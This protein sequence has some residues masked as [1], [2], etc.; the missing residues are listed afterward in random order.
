VLGKENL[1]WRCLIVNFLDLLEPRYFLPNDDELIQ[2]QFQEVFEVVFICK[3]RVIVGYRLF[4]EVFYAKIM[5]KSPI[6]G[7]FSALK[8][9]VSEFLYKPTERIDAF[10]IKKYNFNMIMKEPLAK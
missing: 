4:R 9:K 2:D 5:N 7:D 8:N 1:K 6:V 10:A 3:G